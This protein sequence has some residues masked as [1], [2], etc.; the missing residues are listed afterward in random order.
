MKCNTSSSVFKASEA[1]FLGEVM[2]GILSVSEGSSFYVD[3]PMEVE[4]VVDIKEGSSVTFKGSVGVGMLQ[5]EDGS[6]VKVVSQMTKL[7]FETAADGSQTELKNVV[8][9]E[10]SLLVDGNS[11][12]SVKGI[13][14]KI[15][16]IN[17]IIH[18]PP[19]R[20]VTSHSQRV[21]CGQSFVAPSSCWGHFY[22]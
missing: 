15:T 18:L 20:L 13:V 19:T 21:V 17:S 6:S 1:H 14:P 10:D 12:M 5:I 8:V 16:K 9:I 4:M 3:G 2:T 22:G 11:M 7:L